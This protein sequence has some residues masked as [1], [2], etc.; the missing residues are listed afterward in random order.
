MSV[1]VGVRVGVRWRDEI[2]SCTYPLK[3]RECPSGEQIS[4]ETETKYF[5]EVSLHQ[6]KSL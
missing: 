6:I 4:I 1:G 2:F 3:I 5:L